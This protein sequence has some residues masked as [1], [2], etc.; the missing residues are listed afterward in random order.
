M[1]ENKTCNE[2]EHISY[3]ESEYSKICKKCGFVELFTD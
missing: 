2:G 1:T 3:Q